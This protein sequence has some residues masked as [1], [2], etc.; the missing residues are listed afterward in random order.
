MNKEDRKQYDKQ[1]R[2]DN[3]DKR[4]QYYLD[5]QDKIKQYYL[6]NQDKRKQYRIDNQDKIKQQKKQYYLD[7]QDKIKQHDK[8]YY[9]DNQ[10]K[11][12]QQNKQYYLDNQDKRKQY[13]TDNQ[14]KIKQQKKQYRI[15][16]QDKINQYFRDRRATDPLFKLIC[17]LRIRTNEIFKTKGFKKN[18][19]FKDYLG[20]TPAQ[21]VK[22]LESQ[23]TLGMNWKNIGWG[24]HVDHIKPISLA[25]TEEEAYK[26][27]NYTNLQPL[28]K[29]DNIKKSNTYKP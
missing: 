25:Q 26:L 16:N 6:D 3:Q 14:D 10:D 11:I 9:L 4:K 20:C 21:L 19:H 5:N 8:Q 15:D 1:Y 24:W 12:K 28:W 17:N 2:I 7:N 27:N 23:F 18:K 13:Q 22:H 29:L